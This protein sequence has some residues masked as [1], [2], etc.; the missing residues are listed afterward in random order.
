MQFRYHIR[1][2]QYLVRVPIGTQEYEAQRM[3]R[4]TTLEFPLSVILKTMSTE[5]SVVAVFSF[6]V[7]MCIEAYILYT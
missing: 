3:F 2:S 7:G 1:F 4:S 6:L 5:S